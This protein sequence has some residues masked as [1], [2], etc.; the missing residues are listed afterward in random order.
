MIENIEI[1]KGVVPGHL[2]DDALGG[3]I[4]II[5]KKGAK[6]NLNTSVSYGSFN[7][8]QSNFN[9]LYRDE[10]TGFTVKASGFY[11]SSDNDYKVWGGQVKHIE[12]DGSQVPITARRFYD[13]YRSV[14]GMFQAG[15]TN[16]KW[17][18]Q[19]FV[20]ITGSDDYKEVQHGAFM[21]IHPYKG[22]FLE[23]DALLTNLSYQKKGFVC[24]RVRC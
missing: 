9:G 4:N 2:A 18:D 17:A 12:V 21:T 10:K 14:G 8:F 16:L 23:S 15:F 22:R 24:K 11:N 5:M 3:I 6:S 20:G 7:T 19:F 1:Y 13:A